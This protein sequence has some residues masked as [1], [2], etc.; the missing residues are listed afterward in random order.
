MILY[1][2]NPYSATITVVDSA[3]TAYN[4]TGKTVFFTVKKLTDNGDDD[5]NALIT[6][7]ITNH[8]NPTGG[9]TTLTLTTTQTNI[10]IGDYKWDIRIY[11]ASVQLNTTQGDC[12]V[13]N[14]VTKRIS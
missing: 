12:E 8:T 9:I 14:T 3:G 4:L 11:S 1:K 7:D 10:A 6:K 2:G 5:T 13:K